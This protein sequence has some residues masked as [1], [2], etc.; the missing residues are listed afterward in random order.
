MSSKRTQGDQVY[1]VDTYLAITCLTYSKFSALKAVVQDIL[2]GD[3]PVTF[4]IL[5]AYLTI[6]SRDMPMSESH[7]D[8]RFGI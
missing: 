2:Y 1:L 3:Y 4:C 6:H 8:P 5:F 7:R